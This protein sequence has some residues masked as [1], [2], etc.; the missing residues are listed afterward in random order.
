MEYVK[1]QLPVLVENKAMDGRQYYFLRPL[2]FA[3]PMVSRLR[4]EVAVQRF[5]SEMQHQLKD[6]SLSRTTAN[7]LLWKIFNPP[8][9]FKIL[10]LS[11]R[12][13]KTLVNGRFAVVRFS[14]RGLA[15]NFF[16]TVD[17]YMCISK[18]PPEEKDIDPLEVTQILELVLRELRE[19]QG[20][21]FDIENYYSDPSK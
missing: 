12:S 21:F 3:E 14:L 20:D 19:K 1:L 11:F 8:I 6:F 4:Y 2:F 9:E 7:E 13:G 5:K 15:F 18:R 16:P 10:P 17:N